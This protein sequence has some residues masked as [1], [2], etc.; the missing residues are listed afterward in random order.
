MRGYSFLG[1]A[2]KI[3]RSCIGDVQV[4]TEGTNNDIERTIY[5]GFVD[6]DNAETRV[7]YNVRQ[8]RYLKIYSRWWMRERYTFTYELTYVKFVGLA[9]TDSGNAVYPE[10]CSPWLHRTQRPH[11]LAIDCHMKQLLATYSSK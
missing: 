11:L 5:L 4:I 8:I 2:I 9:P 6:N 7:F 10:L 3:Y 1:L